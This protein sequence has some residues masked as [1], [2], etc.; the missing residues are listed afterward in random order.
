MIEGKFV[1]EFKWIKSNLW[2]VRVSL[3][4]SFLF[5]VGTL[6]LPGKYILIIVYIYILFG[7]K[8]LLFVKTRDKRFD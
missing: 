6:T 3:M 1:N 4:G 8:D 7:I 2:Y 5:R